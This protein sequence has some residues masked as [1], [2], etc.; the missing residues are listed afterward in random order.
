[1][2]PRVQPVSDGFPPGGVQIPASAPM[3]VVG[4]VT[5]KEAGGATR[6]VGTVVGDN[7]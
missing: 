5:A 4:I 7:R 6:R 1:M 2:E 3:T